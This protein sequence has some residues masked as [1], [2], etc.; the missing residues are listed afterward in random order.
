MNNRELDNIDNKKG[1]EAAHFSYFCGSTA[2]VDLGLFYEVPLSHSVG[3]TASG[4]SPL[5]E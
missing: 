2:L 3:H 5:D 4:R 1:R